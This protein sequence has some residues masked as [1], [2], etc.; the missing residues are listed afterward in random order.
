MKPTVRLG[1]TIVAS[2]GLR[3][4]LEL[5]AVP[6]VLDAYRLIGAYAVVEASLYDGSV[7]HLR[8]VAG[9]GVGTWP[10]ILSQDLLTGAAATLWAQ[11][12]LRMDW[13]LHPLISLGLDLLSEHLSVVT[14]NG[15]LAFHF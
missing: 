1:A 14:L 11:L 2:P 7:Y 13:R 3:L 9:A 5:V 4:G 12:G 6:V 15:R 8:A 10:K